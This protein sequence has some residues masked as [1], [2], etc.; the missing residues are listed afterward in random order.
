MSYDKVSPWTVLPRK[1]VRGG[2]F[3][4]GTAFPM[5]PEVYQFWGYRVDWMEKERKQELRWRASI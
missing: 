2:H 1:I 4:E 5:T 3:T